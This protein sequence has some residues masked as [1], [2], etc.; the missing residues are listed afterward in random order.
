MQRNQCP[1]KSRDVTRV[2]NEWTAEMI[3]A[4]LDREWRG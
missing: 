4:V 2:G 1:E 3:Y